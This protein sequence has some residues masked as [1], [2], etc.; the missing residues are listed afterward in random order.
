MAV[1]SNWDIPRIKAVVEQLLAAGAVPPFGLNRETDLDTI[2]VN[3]NVS[4]RLLR[5]VFDPIYPPN[6]LEAEGAPSRHLDDLRELARKVHNTLFPESNTKHRD[7]KAR[8]HNEMLVVPCRQPSVL[9]HALRDLVHLRDGWDVY[10]IGRVIQKMLDTPGA[11]HEPPFGL[12]TDVDLMEL[13][14]GDGIDEGVI[15]ALLDP[16]LNVNVVPPSSPTNQMPRTPLQYA[17]V[18][19]PRILPLLLHIRT[20]MNKSLPDENGETP[21]QSALENERKDVA[22]ALMHAGCGIP[23]RLSDDA[24]Q[25][26]EEEIAGPMRLE[27]LGSMASSRHRANGLIFS[28]R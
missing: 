16:Y 7:L 24:I 3:W 12:N 25:F 14:R 23:Q 9:V 28:P 11:P 18:C 2:H 4:A 8:I 20:D 22:L 6:Y 21:M 15:R 17:M 10:F 27:A 19:H 26:Y 1:P 13:R 5:M